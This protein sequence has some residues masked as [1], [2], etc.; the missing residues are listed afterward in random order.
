[1]K[2]RA[3]CTRHDRFSVQLANPKVT[4]I[5]RIERIVAPGPARPKQGRSEPSSGHQIN[6]SRAFAF[7]VQC[8]GKPRRAS[9][10]SP[11]FARARIP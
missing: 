2:R 8:R 6:P 7:N 3:P 11:P 5:R 4:V 9:V 1:M 10:T